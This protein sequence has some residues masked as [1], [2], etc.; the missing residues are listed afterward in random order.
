VTLITASRCLEGIVIC[1]DSQQISVVDGVEYRMSV[2]KI[3]HYRTNT[4]DL[5]I[6]GGGSS[7][8]I[9]SFCLL[10]KRK[11]DATDI[12]DLGMLR[13][14]VEIELAEFYRTDVALDQNKSEEDLTFLIAA[15]VAGQYEA[16]RSQGIRLQP[17][18]Q[19]GAELI[20]HEE[21][22]Y[23]AI[24]RRHHYPRM[25]IV[26]AVLAGIHVLAI[27]EETSNYVRGPMSVAIVTSAGIKM[28]P[29]V[30]VKDMASRLAN[31]ETKLT[32]LFI[33]C[34]DLNVSATVLKG[35]I[36]VIAQDAMVLHERHVALFGKPVIAVPAYTT[37]MFEYCGEG[38]DIPPLAIKES[39]NKSRVFGMNDDGE[40]APAPG[41]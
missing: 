9:V 31:F 25:Q 8:L 27:A 6:A 39:S 15:V 2:Q 38:G 14:L 21:E 13:D 37:G 11:L 26:Q 18:Q 17:I 33:L 41:D 40:W 4:C 34:A 20:G 36:D 7:K 3:E 32:R 29:D 5:A 16:W 12:Q 1:A 10:M 19:Y 30:Y 23:A 24:A 28:P 22:L 35:E